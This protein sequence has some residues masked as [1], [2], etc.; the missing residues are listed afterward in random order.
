MSKYVRLGGGALLI[1][2]LFCMNASAQLN[3][4]N[5]ASTTIMALTQTGSLGVGIAAP[6]SKLT[7]YGGGTIG[8]GYNLIAAPSNG[9]LVQGRVGIG[10]T[11]PLYQIDISN[12]TTTTNETSIHFGKNTDDTGGYLASQFPTQFVIAGGCAYNGTTGPA[13]T[14]KTTQPT[15]IGSYLGNIYFNNDPSVGV[16]TTFEPTKNMVL[17]GTGTVY[18]GTFK[19][20][21]IGYDGFQIHS[22][23]KLDAI[24]TRSSTVGGRSQIRFR[25]VAAWT[26][27]GEGGGGFLTSAHQSQFGISGGAFRDNDG[28]WKVWGLSTPGTVAPTAIMSYNGNIYFYARPALANGSTWNLATDGSQRMMISSSGYVGIGNTNPGYLLAVGSSGAH[29]DGTTWTP[30]SSRAVKRNIQ[31][32]P[33]DQAY[34]VFRQLEPVSFEYKTRPL[35]DTNLGFIAEDVPELVAERERKNVD[36]MDFIALLT[37]VVQEQDKKIQAYEKRLQALEKQR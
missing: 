27:F 12:N 11:N 1:M 4:K 33:A 30:A 24:T 31:P 10:K 20:S 25:N 18:I 26:E 16:G 35:G 17:G 3:F 19:N 15:S 21:G 9:L 34:E 2:V 7:V 32:L 5:S 23:L 36:P 37:R 13:M 22:E 14:A 28:V 8:T 6:A 29:C